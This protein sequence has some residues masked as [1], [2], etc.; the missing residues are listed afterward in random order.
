MDDMTA[1]QFAMLRY[2][3]EVGVGQWRNPTYRELVKRFGITVFAVACRLKAL[4]KKGY[5]RTD[6][7]EIAVTPMTIDKYFEEWPVP[8]AE[9]DEM[10]EST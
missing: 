10:G 9:D 6:I 7:N 5:L 2:I 4:K 8:S 3:C 1:K